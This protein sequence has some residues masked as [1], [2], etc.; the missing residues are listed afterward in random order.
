M[1]ILSETEF[2]ALEREWEK[3]VPKTQTPTAKTI[4]PTMGTRITRRD[5]NKLILARKKEKVLLLESSLIKNRI[6]GMP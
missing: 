1:N 3:S 6:L 4:L 5:P 2:E